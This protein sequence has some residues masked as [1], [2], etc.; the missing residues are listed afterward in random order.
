MSV[1]RSAEDRP[2]EPILPRWAS[3]TFLLYAGG[4]TILGASLAAL[5]TLADEHGDAAFVGYA[6]LF[7]VA[8]SAVALLLRRDGGHPI[9]AGILAVIAVALFAASSAPSSPGSAGSTMARRS[10]A[11]I[12]RG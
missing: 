4:L 10:A 11:S 1:R 5:S 6:L 12:S 2:V 9:A 8:A 3:W 7:F